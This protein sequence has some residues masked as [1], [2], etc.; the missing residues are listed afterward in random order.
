M[1]DALIGAVARNPSTGAVVPL[2]AKMCRRAY[3]ERPGQTDGALPLAIGDRASG[4]DEAIRTNESVGPPGLRRVGEHA[5]AWHGA[6]PPARSAGRWPGR[7]AGIRSRSGR[8]AR[9]AAPALPA[10]PP[11]YWQPCGSSHGR[12]GPPPG[13]H[14]RAGRLGQP[15]PMWRPGSSVA[16]APAPQRTYHVTVP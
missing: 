2:S 10:A 5:R 8:G 16:W 12:L 4:S 6:R 15:R 7:S 14:V 1:A 9:A 3:A 11:G 13:Q